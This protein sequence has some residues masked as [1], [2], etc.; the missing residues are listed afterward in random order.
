MKFSG[1]SFPGST[2]VY[3]PT[4]KLNVYEDGGEAKY[5]VTKRRYAGKIHPLLLIYPLVD[6]L[7]IAG[8]LPLPV[9]GEL[10]QYLPDLDYHLGIEGTFATQILSNLFVLVIA[11]YFLWPYIRNLFTGVR[12]WHGLEHKLIL[13]AEAGE[14]DLAKQYPVIADKC[15]GT[16]LLTLLVIAGLFS[17]VQ[18]VDYGMYP[19]I[20]VMTVCVI[21]ILI[22]AKTFH[23]S[24]TP[25]LYFGR[26]LQEKVTTSEPTDDMLQVGIRGMKELI[27]CESEK[28]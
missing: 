21:S 10:K 18:Y 5:R 24:N 27:V 1:I 22:E 15:G 8:H 26:W 12:P 14:P 25:G 13:S 20:G 28:C 19:P 4:H 23:E 9:V 11:Y 3:G 6:I 7:L 2:T 16:Y 17:L